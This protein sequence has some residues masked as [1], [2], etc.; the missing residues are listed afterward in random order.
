MPRVLRE[1]GDRDQICISYFIR[2]TNVCSPA[3]EKR[4]VKNRAANDLKTH[5]SNSSSNNSNNG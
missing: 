1:T 4:R 5:S 3:E 2:V